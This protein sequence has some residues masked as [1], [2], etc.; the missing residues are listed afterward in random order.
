MVMKIC[1]V[2][3]GFKKCFFYCIVVVDFCM[4]CDGCFIEKLGIYNFL[5]L[6]DSEECVK[7][8]VECIQYWVG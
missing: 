1:F 7:M 4:L 6:K 3:G 8:D 2:C 5:L